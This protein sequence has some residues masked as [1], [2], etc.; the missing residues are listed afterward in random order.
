MRRQSS[1]PLIQ[2]A[3]RKP[4]YLVG[5]CMQGIEMKPRRFVDKV[6]DLSSYYLRRECQR[7]VRTRF[8]ASRMLCEGQ[9]NA[10]SIAEQV[11]NKMCMLGTKFWMNLDNIDYK[12]RDKY[13]QIVE[14][15]Q[16]CLIFLPV[17]RG[18]AG[19]HFYEG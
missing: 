14:R 6:L 3:G 1:N 19:I 12:F 7:M 5:G 15:I 11:I 16:Y 8:R 9:K 10:A 2:F 13:A 17:I 4:P 18:S